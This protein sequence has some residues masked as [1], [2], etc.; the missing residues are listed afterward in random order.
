MKASDN[1]YP[2]VRFAPGSAPA[3]PPSGQVVIFFDS[4]DGSLK[5]KDSTGTVKAV[6]ASSGGGG[7]RD[8]RWFVPSGSVSIDEFN[9]DTIDP[10]WVR[11]DGTGAPAAN[12]TWAEKGD[13]LSVYN[14]GGDTANRLHALVRPLSAFGGAVNPGDAFVTAV[15]MFCSTGTFFMGGI[16]LADGATADAGNQ[17]V[18]LVYNAGGFTVNAWAGT[19]WSFSGQTAD[20]LTS[21]QQ[22]FV[23]LVCLTATTWRADLSPDGVQWMLGTAL[24]KTVAPTHVGLVSSTWGS[25]VKGIV[26]Y[27][28][29][30]RVSGV[31]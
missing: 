8:L 23:R 29:L 4:T 16:V 27:E 30:R 19:G 11:L 20:M 9:D 3:T 15:H 18:G 7:N 6:G 2:L 31:S 13:A 5:S 12:A 1:V 17:V 24:T 26:K 21:S 25:S 22:M 10:A 28:F 14:A